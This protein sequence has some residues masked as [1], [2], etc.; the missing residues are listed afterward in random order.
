MIKQMSRLQIIGPKALLDRCV[1]ALHSEAVAHVETVSG[2]EGSFFERLPL[3]IERLR[4]KERLEKAAERLKNLLALLLPPENYSVER[5]NSGDIDALLEGLIPV[6]ASVKEVRARKDEMAEELSVVN[7]YERLLQGFAPV[8]SRLGGLK[9]FDIIGLTLEKVRSD[10]AVILEQEVGRITSGRYQAFVK[11]LDSETVGV[12]LAYPK[13]FEPSVRQL[14]SG[15]AINEVRLPDEY[16]E[17]SLLAAL[18]VMGK[19][20]A[21]LPWRIDEADSEL[22]AL[23]Q[24]WYGVIK[25]LAR[26]IDDELD[27]I[28]VL[29]Y[30]GQTRFTFIIEGWV[31][32]DALPGLQSGMAKEFGER[33][34]VRGFPVKKGEE[35]RVPV[36]ISNPAALRPFEVFL[37]ALTPPRYGSVDPTPYVALFFP[38]FFGLIVGDIGYGGLIFII[39]LL[40]KKR[41]AHDRRLSD[42]NYVVSI[43]AVSAIVFGVL[44]GEFFGDLGERLGLIHPIVLDR[45]GSLKTLLALAIAT[46]AGHVI[47]G[48]AIGAVNTIR[49][50]KARAAWARLSYLAAV[51]SL[52]V[53]GG[54]FTGHLTRQFLAPGAVVFV[55]SF[56]ILAVT[57]GIL[58]PLEL[59]K[60]LGNMLSYVRLMAVGT[61]SVVMAIVANRMGALSDDLIIGVM[62]AVIIHTLNLMLSV[63]SPSI[64]SM[65]LQYVEFF[66]KF[67]EGGGKAY[68]PFKKRQSGR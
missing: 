62:I 60:T 6:E 58:G 18:K 22:R 23:S 24:R 32:T 31:P 55:I 47:L 53:I 64:Q 41:L 61:A 10:V 52:I 51:V 66:S 46:G 40:L 17:M 21:E 42:I 4:E 3:E 48:I 37:S 13:E 59:V 12:V 35:D 25:G 26:I 57:E 34:I 43:G 33:V 45:I 68:L 36:C 49:R 63:V 54:A 38:T 39:S 30:A 20:K 65:R 27:E 5:T 56:V 11:D 8:V 29:A 14:L 7:R 50:R 1:R 2:G 16:A 67:Y 9:T 19:R 44:F 28:G 15:Q